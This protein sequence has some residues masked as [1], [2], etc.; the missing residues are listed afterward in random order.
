MS[1]VALVNN[2]GNPMRLNNRRWAALAVA[3]LMLAGFDTNAKA[4]DIGLT[5]LMTAALDGD[6]EVVKLLLESG[7]DVDAKGSDGYTALMVVAGVGETEV[8]K[9]LIESGAKAP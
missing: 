2:K 3:A 5:A 8:A 4:D 6:A 1:T 9:L 7:A